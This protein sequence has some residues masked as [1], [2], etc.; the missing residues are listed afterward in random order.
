MRLHSF[1]LAFGAVSVVEWDCF[2][3]GTK[4]CILASFSMLSLGPR[5][6]DTLGSRAIH[7]STVDRIPLTEIGDFPIE[8]PTNI[9]EQR[10]IAH[11]LGT[12]DDKIEL[13]QRMNQTLEE[14]AR[15]LF[16]SWF[17]DFDPVRAK[18]TLK[19][20]DAT[21]PQGESERS[22]ER[23]RAYLDSM[24]P[25]IL[26]LFPDRFVDSE[27]GPIPVGW[28]RKALDEI[29]VFRNGLALQKYRPQGNEDWLP[30]VKIAQ[31]RSGESDSERELLLLRS[32]QSVSSKMEML[33]FRGLGASW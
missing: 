10:A 6:Q 12:L 33:S 5:F 29:A 26:A 3:R 23:A 27:L 11:I 15:A 32:V 30:V 22:V 25:K 13:N 19:R 17:V 21:H 28:E 4:R 20:H 1:L 8:I 7:G 24:D 18:A 14:M 9:C 31:L 2:A 16:K